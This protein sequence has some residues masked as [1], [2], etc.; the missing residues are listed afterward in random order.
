MTFE[1]PWQA[2]SRKLL[3]W[4]SRCGTTPGQRR[5][6]LALLRQYLDQLGLEAD[7]VIY[8]GAVYELPSPRGRSTMAES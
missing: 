5:S 7:R 3:Q 6:R 4:V 2:V 8:K 1:K